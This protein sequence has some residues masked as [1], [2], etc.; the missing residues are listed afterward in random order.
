MS[1]L[2]L[3]ASHLEKFLS[4]LFYVLIVYPIV[5]IST[6]SLIDYA[7]FEIIKFSYPDTPMESVILII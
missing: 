4:G 6:H 5:I 1:Y 3:P 7:A 2:L